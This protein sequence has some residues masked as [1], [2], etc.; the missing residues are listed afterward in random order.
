MPVSFKEEVIEMNVS[1][2]IKKFNQSKEDYRKDIM[3]PIF[4]EVPAKNVRIYGY[5]G[6][7]FYIVKIPYKRR[8]HC[9]A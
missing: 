5:S 4:L 3:E 6:F 8:V 2:I 9:A 7:Y 1:E